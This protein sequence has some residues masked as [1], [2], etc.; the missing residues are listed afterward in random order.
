MLGI[1]YKIFYHSNWWFA[2][3]LNPSTVGSMWKC[4]GKCC[5]CIYLNGRILFIFRCIPTN[6]VAGWYG[7]LACTTFLFFVILSSG[8]WNALFVVLLKS[9]DVD[10]HEFRVAGPWLQEE[11]WCFAIAKRWFQNWNCK[12]KNIRF[13]VFQTDHPDS[14]LMMMWIFFVNEMEHAICYLY[15]PYKKWIWGTPPSFHIVWI[16]SSMDI[17]RFL[18]I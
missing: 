16:C 15:S 12:K 14:S 7:A 9:P 1:W 6:M 18:V 11:I 3:C 2:G 13:C 4:V 10:A 8:T 17:G 5:R